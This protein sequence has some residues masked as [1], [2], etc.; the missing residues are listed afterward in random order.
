MRSVVVVLP[1]SMCAMIPM[2]RVRA[3][4]YSRLTSAPLPDP[5]VCWPFSIFSAVSATDSRSF[6]GVAISDPAHRTPGPRARLGGA[7]RSPSVVR[8]GAVRLRHLVHVLATL[9]RDA[10]ALGGV[11]DLPDQP[12]GHRVL[13]ALAREVRE[14]TE[15]ERRA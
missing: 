13:C 7:H 2:F 8:E 3:S 4:G 1:A 12:L 11:H 14:P 10:V 6:A 5:P 9:H 15:R